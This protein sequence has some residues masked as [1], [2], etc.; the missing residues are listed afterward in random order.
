M[1]TGNAPDVDREALFR[2]PP[3]AE[4]VSPA[5]G[6]L[7]AAPAPPDET[8][9]WADWCRIMAGNREFRMLHIGIGGNAAWTC[10]LQPH[11]IRPVRIIANPPY[12]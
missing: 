9:F 5:N 8:R 3:Q 1:D 7:L 6:E 2:Q 11:G 12:Q 10:F 4:W